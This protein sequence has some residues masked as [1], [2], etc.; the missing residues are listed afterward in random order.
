MAMA[1]DF[2]LAVGSLSFGSAAL[3][4]A[5]YL[6]QA[7]RRCKTRASSCEP[8][9]Q[10]IESKEQ[11]LSEEAVAEEEKAAVPPK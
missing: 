5:S 8:S 6:S 3:S 9:G 11:G 4:I 2:G 7:T 10:S 1:F